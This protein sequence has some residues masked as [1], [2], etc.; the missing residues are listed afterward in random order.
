MIKVL[1]IIIA[2]LILY[3]CGPEL[4]HCVETCKKE[5][6]GMESYNGNTFFGSKCTCQKAS[7]CSELKKVSK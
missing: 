5:S 2:A 1:A 4:V 3:G 6:C 7:S